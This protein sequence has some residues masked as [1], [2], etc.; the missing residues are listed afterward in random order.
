MLHM[1]VP[2][3]SRHHIHASVHAGDSHNMLWSQES[4]SNDLKTPPTRIVFKVTSV[5]NSPS[6]MCLTWAVD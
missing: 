6:G 5:W 3:L 4:H 1:I 2:V